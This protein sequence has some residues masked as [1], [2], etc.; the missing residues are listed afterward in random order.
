MKSKGRLGLGIAGLLLTGGLV[1]GPLGCTTNNNVT[2]P[3]PVVVISTP[4]APTST[5]T[6]I[7]GAGMAWVQALASTGSPVS[8][9]FTRRSNQGSVSLNGALWLEGGQSGTFRND[10]W[11]SADGVHWT[12]VLADTSTPASTQ[13]SQRY[14]NTFLAYNGALWVIGGYNSGTGN[15]NDVWS[16]TDGMTWTQVLANNASP[17]LGQFSQRAGHASAVFN[18]LMWVIAGV[19]GTLQSDVWA[20]ADGATWTQVTAGAAFGGRGDH[21][22]AAY[23][24]FLWVTGGYVGGSSDVNDVWKSADGQTWIQVLADN[25]S[26]PST[27]FSRREGHRLEA[28]NGALWLLAGE[29]RTPT[30]FNDVWT[31]TDGST[32]SQPAAVPPFPVRAYLSSAVF[33]NRLWI[34]GGVGS[35]GY[36]NDVWYTP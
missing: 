32:W 6:P 12:Q 3:A 31:S 14:G 18:G 22:A 1:F 33:N 13:F 24:G 15:L 9:Q 8:T 5:P 21:A 10:V 7:Q 26:P 29:N 17:G 23:G 27:Q 30:Y 28:Y 16:S 2:T 34:L 20:S 25:A 4:G 11:K 36:L 35:G 19:G